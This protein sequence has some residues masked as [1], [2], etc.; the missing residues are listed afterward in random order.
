LIDCHVYHDELEDVTWEKCSLR[1]W[2]NEEFIFKAF[3]E[4]ERSRIVKVCNQNR[5]NPWWGTEGGKATWD[6]VFALSIEEADKYFDDNM[7]MRAA[8][9]SYARSPHEGKLGSGVSEKYKTTDGQWTGWWW[10]RSPG[11]YSHYAAYVI[12]DG[13]VYEHG[14]YVNDSSVSVRPALWLHL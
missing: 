2:L 11:D 8:V 6:R 7:D 12:S 4:Q 14:Y 3:D 1:K 13:E 5:D 10:L 9:T